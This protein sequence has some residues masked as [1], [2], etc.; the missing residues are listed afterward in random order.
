M[1]QFDKWRITNTGALLARQYDHL[2]REL[3]VVGELPDG[4]SWDVL[5][6]AGKRL[7]I[8][9]LSPAEGGLSVTLTAEM[10]AL[11]GYYAIQLRGIQGEQVRHTNVIQ[12]YVGPSLSGDAQ[13]PTIPTEFTQLEQRVQA[14]AAEAQASAEAAAQSAQDAESAAQDA[15]DQTAQQL[16]SKF[17]ALAKEASDSAQSAEASAQSASA[18]AGSAAQS[19]SAAWASANQAA[20]SAQSAAAASSAAAQSASGA[21]DAAGTAKSAATQAQQSAE[22]ASK[23]A[24]TAGDH[25]ADADQSAKSAAD[26]QASAETAAGNAEQSANAAAQSAQEAEAAAENAKTIIDDTTAQMGKT[27]SSLTIVDRLA[28]AFESSGPVVT[29]A[30][31]EGYPLHVVSQIVPVQEGEGDPSPDNVRPISGWN[32]AT[33]WVGGAN[34]INISEDVIIPQANYSI[35]IRSGSFFD[36]VKSLPKGKTLFMSWDDVG[37]NP[38]SGTS[39]MISFYKNGVSQNFKMQKNI[40]FMIPDGIE[41][42]ALLCYAGQGKTQDAVWSNFRCGPTLESVAEYTP[43]NP[44]SKTITL[45]FGQ[46]V[47]GG[48]LDW[49][50]GMLTVTTKFFSLTGDERWEY[51]ST[52]NGIARYWFIGTG[53][54]GTGTTYLIS[55]QFKRIADS[56]VYEVGVY[57]TGAATN[58]IINI[59]MDS[60]GYPDVESFKSFLRQKNAEGT[61]VEIV[62][63]I[64]VPY[65]IQL[66][67]QEILAL[68]GVNTIYTDTG[69]TTV[70]GRADPNTI[71]QQLAA[72]IAALE[73][74]V[75]SN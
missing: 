33:L 42:D 63:Q 39:N 51:V 8:I 67:P 27:W 17:E 49:T 71:I 12:V 32:E 31:V 24:Q 58:G 23:Q 41:F 38:G 64:G 53:A 70:S 16:Q 30:P 54:H 7:D 66:T 73:S 37:T 44:A 48:E 10:L 20:A 1:I 29:C 36:A 15:A 5:V 26:A 18:A 74:A 28:P 47:Y 19:A 59:H 50:T 75:V 22:S 57:V 45:P 6:Q 3:R 72:R 35:S 34:I 25:A 11:G 9:R 65:T 13:W 43:Y 14:S 61:P 21:T 2:T 52:N 60:E 46:T 56:S 55:S 68:S 40:S 62:S 69:D 4:W